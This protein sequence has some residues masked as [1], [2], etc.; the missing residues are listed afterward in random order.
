MLNP[1]NQPAN[2]PVK[3][4]SNG[5][6]GLGALVLLIM[7]IV[8]FGAGYFIETVLVLGLI[9]VLLVALKASNKQA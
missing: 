5:W 9:T 7:L 8:G 1:E 2:V 3:K 4:E 6:A